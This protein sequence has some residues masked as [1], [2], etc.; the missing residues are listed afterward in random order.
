MINLIKTIMAKLVTKRFVPTPEEAGQ[1]EQPMS[2]IEVLESIMRYKKQN[3]AKY[4]LK[5]E[6]LFARYGLDINDEPVELKDAE[7]EELE[8]IK[9]RVTKAK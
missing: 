6:A 3:P 5:K 4:L 1:G 2:K 7:D 9:K 8:A